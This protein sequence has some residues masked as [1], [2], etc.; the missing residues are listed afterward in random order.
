MDWQDF[1]VL[2]RDLLKHEFSNENCKVEV[3]RASRD[4]GVD[5]IAFDEDPIRGGK[6]VIQAKRYNNIVPLSAVRDLYG[7]VMNE[8]AVKGILVTTSYY[9]KDALEF[10]K[11]KP[12]KLINGEELVYMFNKYGYNMKIELAKKQKAQSKINY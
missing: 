3:T 10:V 5:A 4:A 7:T 2:I 1:E 6:Y 9:G 8:G 11:D 12:L